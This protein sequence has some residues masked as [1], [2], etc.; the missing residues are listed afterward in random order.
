MLALIV[1]TLVALVVVIGIVSVA[2]SPG[3]VKVGDDGV[4]VVDLSRQYKEQ[5]QSNPLGGLVANADDIPGLYILVQLID[6]AKTD[7]SIKGIYIKCNG[8]ANGYAASEEIRNALLNFKK[9]KKFVIA[10]GEMISQD[11]YYVATV[12]DKVYCNPKGIVEWKGLSSTLVFFKG[13]LEKLDIKP[14]IFY[15]GKF[16][17]AT[18][19]FRNIK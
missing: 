13:T 14:Q 8:N 18:E 10:Y 19:P 12:A 17:S 4:L 15:A 3:K 5:K 2:S 6:H 16:K 1:F 9:S 11:A 7:E